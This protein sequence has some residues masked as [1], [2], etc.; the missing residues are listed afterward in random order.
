MRLLVFG[1]ISH[2]GFG[3]VTEA[4]AREFLL[5]GVDVR[6][7]AV[8]HRGEP[9]RGDLSGRVW[10]A[11][12]FGDAFG[13]NLSSAAIDGS[14]WLK[15]DA[16]DAWTPDQVLV[17]SDMSGFQG[18]IGKAVTP[19]WTSLPVWH[20]CPIE[21]DNLPPSWREIWEP[22][23]PVAMSTYGA[24]VISAHCARPVPMIPHGVDCDTFR[25]VTVGAAVHDGKT[26]RTRE[27]A[28]AAFGLDPARKVVLR[29]DRFVPRKFYHSLLST[30]A[31]VF[32]RDPLVDLVMHCRPQDEGGNL[33]EEIGRL[34]RE[35][36]GR[37]KLTNAHDTWRG[38][39][40]ESL[41]VLMN[42]AD[43]YV[44]TTSGEGFGLTLAESLACG[45]PVVCTDWAADAETVGPGGV[46]VPVL[47]DSRGAPVTFHSTYGM[48]WGVPDP[49]AFTDPIVELLAKPHRRRA[50]GDA[51][52][53]HVRR[54]FVW[55]ESADKF[56]DLFASARRAEAAA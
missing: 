8:N 17:V 32:T 39:P 15:L 27:Q 56:M 37:V 1:H 51:G 36:W 19:Q 43:L 14:L 6:I 11:S 53:A 54:S 47:H 41:V 45:V 18:H 38:L 42:A 20:Y 3:V 40:T 35:M 10:P 31:E 12:M 30:M 52:R 16:E 7:I 46:L 33:L 22:F 13:G 26:V 4:L 44:S 25:P 9:V 48:D 49:A 21:G 29:T 23:R 50:M 2:T 34:P 24:N 5:R 28:K 55:A